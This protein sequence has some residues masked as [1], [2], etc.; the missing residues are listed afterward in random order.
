MG[1]WTTILAAVL[2]LA[3][4][5]GITALAAGAAEAALSPAAAPAATQTVTPEEERSLAVRA[6]RA[7][8]CRRLGDLV[9]AAPLPDGRT[10]GAAFGAGGDREVVL[11]LL[12]R[13]ARAV[14]DARVYSDGV[15]EVDVEIPADM[16]LQQVGQWLRP[17][18]PAALDGLRRQVIDGCLG[19]SGRVVP[20]LNV[21]SE[22]VHRAAAARPEEVVPCYPVGWEDVTAAG[23]VEAQSR[24]RV[25]A[26]EAMGAK[27]RA[28][29]LGSGGTVGSMVK[30]SAGAEAMLDAFVRSL[31]LAGPVRLMPDRLAEAEVAAPVR[32]FIKVLRNIQ[33]LAP[34]DSP[35]AKAQIDELSVT[36]KSEQI[37]ATGRGLPPAEG[38]RP[39]E[40]VAPT[41]PLPD[42]AAGVLEASAR[43]R[44]PA[45]VDN[46][47][48]TRLL[49][50]RAAKAKAL[51]DL[52][53]KLDAVKLED[54][55]TIRQRA[56]KDEVF[57]R[58]IGVFLKSA[59]I[60]E[61]RATG[62]QEWGV[63]LRLPLVRAWEFS[64]PKMP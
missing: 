12:V 27:L 4:T 28:V 52:Q 5:A 39:P 50:A 44:F 54:G 24:A 29:R 41:L 14:G 59:R 62:N 43:A 31:A 2:T 21:P 48:Q 58:D 6:A 36:L 23:R 33:T 51:E 55:R 22:E 46:P 15:T 17:V 63:T 34:A 9:M 19:S 10:F 13:S 37:L 26:Y 57:S 47:D 18:D 20:P 8:A 64:Q 45:D 38:V 25:Q 56:A 35:W 42:W 3:S 16:V 1:N 30:D 53:R 61:S 11:R 7:D 49:A 40:T 60:V 32:D